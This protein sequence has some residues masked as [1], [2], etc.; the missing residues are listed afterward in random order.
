MAIVRMAAGKAA[1]VETTGVR[2]AVTA[3]A[4]G[5]VS[6]VRPRSISIS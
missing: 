6:K 4:T 1:G 5:D 3:A 2:I